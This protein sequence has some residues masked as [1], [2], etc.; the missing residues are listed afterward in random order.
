MTRVAVLA[1]GSGT[2]LQA[3]LDHQSVLG[4]A[5]SAH[6][7]LVASDH[8][9][10]G[11]L[12]RARD[13]GVTAV[14]LDRASRTTGLDAI[15]AAHRIELVALAGYLRLIPIDVV[16]RF[17][18]RLLNVHPALLPD[19]GGHGMYGSR[20]HEAVMA[21]GAR[22]TGPT[23]HFV[24]ARYD[25]G[26]IIAQW[27]VPIL[28]SDTVESVAAR[29]LAVEHLL[30]PRIVEAVAAGL[31]HLDGKNQVRYENGV[32]AQQLQVTADIGAATEHLDAILRRARMQSS[33]SSDL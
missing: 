18:G 4:S 33:L 12:T 29:V 32:D 3:I 6:V 23:V 2:N 10:A 11:A 1:S 16:T 22:L 31:I 21:R 26:P 28:A 25:E 27:P 30:Y 17:R 7:V 19:F 9:D 14:A 8:A 15:L 24:D 13:A 20:V 5:A